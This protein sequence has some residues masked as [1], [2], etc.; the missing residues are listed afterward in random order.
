M[1]RH[2]N[3]RDK[4]N[5]TET[6]QRDQYIEDRR[7]IAK[8]LEKNMKGPQAAKVLHRFWWYRCED[9]EIEVVMGRK[10]E[11]VRPVRLTINDEDIEE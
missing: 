9:G 7:F 4:A 10:R 1:G 2:Q 8:F 5:K 3:K 11:Y 6:E